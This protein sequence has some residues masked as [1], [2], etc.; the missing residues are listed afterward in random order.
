MIFSTLQFLVTTLLAVVCA[1]AISLSEGDIPVI[2]LM[3]PALWILP[4]G[5]FA[6]LVLL[7]AMT[8]YGVTLSMQPI[9]L[10]IGTLVLFP[11]LM[12]VFSRRSSLGV[13]LTAGLIV[14]T[15]QV[16]IMVT[17]QAG[18]LDGSPWLTVLQTLSVV[19]MWW[20]A[21]SWR[22]S[23]KHS[24]WSLLL[25]L[26]LWIAGLPY[27]VLLALGITGI[28][29]S[30]EA[31]TKIKNSIRWGKLLCWTLPTVGF[32]ALVVSPNIEVPN[33]VFVVWIC[34]LGTAWMT[35]YILR[36]SD[37]QAEL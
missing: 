21:R 34:L 35:D 23:E 22:P 28:L 26:P 27:A 5:G 31:L 18:K 14:L 9:A 20:A 11:L 32:A 25:L 2:A 12:V 15:L 19:V 7:G 33:P 30:M 8:V 37:E 24:W 1:R 36:S 6:G 17:Q 13:L 3:I 29:A 10:S 16:G 4:Q